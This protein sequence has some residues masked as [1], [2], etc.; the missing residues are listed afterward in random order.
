MKLEIPPDASVA[1]LSSSVASVSVTS[2]EG[3]AVGGVGG[4]KEETSVFLQPGTG[5]TFSNFWLAVSEGFLLLP[6]IESTDLLA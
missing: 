5:W 1:L 2:C 4:W 3:K 6:Q